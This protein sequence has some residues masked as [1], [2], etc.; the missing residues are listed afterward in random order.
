MYN[1]VVRPAVTYRS[2]IGAEPGI[3]GKIPERVIKPL[4]SIQRKCLKIVTGAFN[5][6]SSKVLEDETSTLPMEI[7]LKQRRVQ[8]AGLSESLPVQ[9]TI[10]SACRKIKQPR[11]ER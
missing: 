6:T 5:S 1:A 9:D 11:A 2:P 4:R 3:A 7:Y 8:H 10:S